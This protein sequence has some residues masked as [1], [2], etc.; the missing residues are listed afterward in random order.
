MVGPSEDPISQNIANEAAH[1][2]AAA[3]G[4]NLTGEEK[5]AL[6]R[7]LAADPL[8]AQ[9]Y[10]EMQDLWSHMGRVPE[11]SSLRASLAGPPQRRRWRQ[12]SRSIWPRRH[13]WFGPAI[14]A[15][16]ALIFIGVAQDW[17][18][19]LQA[20][21]MTATGERRTITL[22]DGSTVYLDTQSAIAFSFADDRRLIRLLRGEAAFVVAPDPKRLFTVEAKGGSA[23]ALGTRFLVRGE[24]GGAQVIVTEHSV[25]VAYPVEEG[26]SK[27][28]RE[29][30]SVTYDGNGLE[31]V[32]EV[33]T[34]DAMAW[35]E[36]VLVFQDKPLVDVVAEIGRYH[37]GYMG[38]L[39]NARALRVS[40]VFRI[41]DPVAAIGQLQRSLGLRSTRI[42]DRL[43]LLS[44]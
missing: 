1:W 37:R 14:A 43:I 15:G 40:G 31:R 5:L 6:A 12:A 20:D 3:E 30:Q 33:N 25:R 19:R 35:T 22:P 8:H 41:D 23:T 26:A 4:D 27:I 32:M 13:P 9:A 16:L 42:G 21:A 29:G 10:A 44:S 24:E 17:P 7:W 34:S 2:L 36:G 28:V 18:T 39:G 11:T 38:V